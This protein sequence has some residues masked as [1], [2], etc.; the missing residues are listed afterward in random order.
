MSLKFA[1]LGLLAE[2]PMHGYEMKQFFAAS[3]AQLWHVSP[4]HLYPLLRKIVDEGLAH[5]Q[6]LAQQGKPDAQVY[7]ITDQGRA[8]FRTW[9]DQCDEG[10]PVIR[11]DFMLKLFFY[12]G[13]ER[14]QALAEI[15]A[16]KRSHQ[17]F[18]DNLK[19]K[20]RGIA[21]HADAYQQLVIEGGIHMAQCGIQWLEQVQQQVEKEG[22]Q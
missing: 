2:R 13:K 20:Q 6:R 14:Q 12:S 5:K 10:M 21:A 4:G 19:E 8:A 7:H 9:L 18:I 11:Y 22:K 15:Q 17:T 16:L 1:V 3:F